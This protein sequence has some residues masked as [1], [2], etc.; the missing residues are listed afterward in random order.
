MGA[1]ARRQRAGQDRGRAGALARAAALHAGPCV[2]VGLGA[3]GGRRRASGTR[4][5]P[6]KRSWPTS[7]GCAPRGHLR[8]IAAATR[9][10]ALQALA[11]KWP[12]ETTRGLLAQRAVKDDNENT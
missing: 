12:D 7:A 1:P 10:A 3:S 6:A 11:E 5:G 4:S 9:S 8:G 2:R